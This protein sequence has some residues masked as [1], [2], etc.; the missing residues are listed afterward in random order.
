MSKRNAKT[1]AAKHQQEVAGLKQEIA[2]LRFLLRR[3]QRIGAC[4]QS[5]L[6][7][8][9]LTHSEMAAKVYM[10]DRRDLDFMPVIHGGR[11]RIIWLAEQLAKQEE[12][13]TELQ[14]QV[15]QFQDEKNKQSSPSAIR[16]GAF[17]EVIDAIAELKIQ[18]EKEAGV[19]G[20]SSYRAFGT[21]ALSGHQQVTLKLFDLI[22]QEAGTT[23]AAIRTVSPM[24]DVANG[25]HK[26]L[27]NTTYAE[28]S[29]S[30]GGY[31]NECHICCRTFQGFKRHP[32]CK[33]CT[34]VEP[35]Q[36]N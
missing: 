35:A 10:L 5:E 33:A 6:S 30:A 28:R 12:Q 17:Y 1:Y 2:E 4:T 32:V 34:A 7:Y 3:Y 18:N 21:G 31:Q 29:Y 9:G 26:V 16:A 23:G 8:S 20:M 13:V 11:D 36:P 22:G 25:T 19:D 14:K 27:K 15:Q 24:A